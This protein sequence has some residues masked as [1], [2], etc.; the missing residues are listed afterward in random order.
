VKKE[1]L[2][3]VLESPFSTPEDIQQAEKLLDALNPKPVGGPVEVAP[4]NSAVSERLAKY[5][6]SFAD[7]GTTDDMT[8]EEVAHS[9]EFFKTLRRNSPE[10]NRWYISEDAEKSYHNS[11]RAKA[12]LK[13][14]REDH[15]TNDAMWTD[16][17]ERA[18]AAD[19][20]VSDHDLK[21]RTCDLLMQDQ[22]QHISWRF[23]DGHP[24]KVRWTD[25]SEQVAAEILIPAPKAE[26]TSTQVAPA[27]APAPVA[28]KPTI[29]DEIK[30]LRLNQ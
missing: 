11:P 27:P 2:L 6:A 22:Q 8:P 15:A 25:A 23:A 24:E 9:K 4:Q 5:E 17:T 30:A 19:P 7:H 10:A 3:A 29:W 26:P 14:A 1:K 20:D 13:F 28:L 18:R 12:G 16:L 21:Y